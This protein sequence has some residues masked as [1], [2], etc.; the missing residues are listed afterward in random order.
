MKSATSVV[1]RRD[2]LKSTAA[3]SVASALEPAVLAGAAPAAAP[4][5]GLKMI[6]MQIGAVSFVDEGI[7]QTLD[8]LQSGGAVNTLFLTTFSYG[9]G[10][11]GRQVPGQ[12]FPDHGAQESDEKTFHG[13]NY[14]KP[15]PEFYGNT[16]LKQTRAPDF[17]DLDI[18]EAVLPKARTRGLKVFCSCED[19]WRSSVPGFEA[20]TE[21]DLN[22]RRAGS[23]CLFNPDVRN[24]WT[25]LATD[26]CRSYDVDG[27][28]FFNERNGPLLNALGASHAQSIASGRVTCFCD[29]HRK[30]AEA[31]GID[32]NRA[33]EGYR[34]LDEFVQQ[35]LTGQRPSDGYFVEFWRVLVENPEILAW[36]RLFDLGKHQVLTDVRAAVKAVRPSLQVG[37]HIEHVNSF[38][39]IFRATRRYD[40]LAA[41]ADFLKVVVY[42]NCGGERYAHFIEN[43]GSTVFRDVP[44][45][46]L[47]RF[48]N[49]LLNY[50]DEAGLGDLPK[51]GL[52]ADYVARETKRALAGVQGKCKV[53]PGIDIGI[54]TGRNSRKAS[55]ED[56]YA[57]V[58][59]ALKAG[60]DGI[61]LSRK[62]SEMRLANVS[63]AGKAVRDCAV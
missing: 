24:F 4:A 31:H 52:S 51:A 28:L 58:A 57:A 56:T 9:R 27:V 7:E 22:G 15:H 46:E 17:G 23:Q 59:A 36:D 37:F 32:I 1:S 26:Y 25:A 35:A 45:D 20:V 48:N 21:V 5:S 60:A 18:L 43:V 29:H 42:N 62:Y 54:P 10:L 3:L 53:L 6:G 47:L 33:R 38:N 50:G 34:K 41:K 55:S 14:A 19:V 13:G 49:H 61:I 30:A 8:L 63:A 12:P 40:D 44:K 39:P 11:A 2:F 16:T